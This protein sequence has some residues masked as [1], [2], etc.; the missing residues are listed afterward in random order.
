MTDAYTLIRMEIA[1]ILF[2]DQDMQQTL[3]QPITRKYIPDW[4]IELLD[5]FN[6]ELV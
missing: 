4:V 6:R 1:L 2:S 5:R 3:Y